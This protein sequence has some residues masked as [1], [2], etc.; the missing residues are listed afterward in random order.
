VLRR[1][2]KAKK[3]YSS[4]WNQ[5]TPFREHWQTTRNQIPWSVF[6]AK[7]AVASSGSKSHWRHDL[8]AFVPIPQ[9]SLLL[10][11][12]SLR[13]LGFLLL[14]VHLGQFPPQFHQFT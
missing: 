12:C 13:D 2:E 1:R 10:F 9:A 8:A 7:R 3:T 11:G 5:F 4:P 6:G 14:L